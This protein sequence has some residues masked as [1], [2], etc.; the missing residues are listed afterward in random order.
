[1]AGPGVLDPAVLDSLRKLTPAGEPDV[2]GEIL[3][4][5]LDDVP[6]RIERLRAALG[7][8]DAVGLQRAAHSLKGSSGNIGAHA[9]YEAARRL[10][11]IGKAGDLAAAV[12]AIDALAGE[13]GKVEAEIRRLLG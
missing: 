9:L 13:Y 8:G 11:E 3:T 7:A 5:F 6:R 12:P 2:L 10:D 1:M 4:T